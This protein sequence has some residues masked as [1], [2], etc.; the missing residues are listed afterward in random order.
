MDT[1]KLFSFNHLPGQ[2]DGQEKKLSAGRQL[3]RNS[4]WSRDTG[5]STTGGNTS[6]QH[7]FVDTNIGKC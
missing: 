4:T 6:S 7:S 2:I 5:Y 3:G 1:I